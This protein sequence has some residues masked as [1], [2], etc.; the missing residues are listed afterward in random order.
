[1][2]KPTNRVELGEYL[3]VHPRLVREPADHSSR[4]VREAYLDDDKVWFRGGCEFV[5]LKDEVYT[6]D[7]FEV[8]NH[9]GQTLRY[10]YAD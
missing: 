9:Y 1:M 7:G 5:T 4:P 2:N 6:S 10:R 8:V 3:K